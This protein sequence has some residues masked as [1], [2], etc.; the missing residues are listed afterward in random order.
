MAY[1]A[2]RVFAQRIGIALHL[3]EQRGFEPYFPQIR[4]E[5]GRVE[6]LFAHY[7]FLVA[8]DQ[9]CEARYCPGVVQLIGGRDDRPATIS[10]AVVDGLRARERGGLVEL[11]PPPAPP[12]LRRGAP[13]RITY[14]PFAG[15]GGTVWLHRGQ[16]G[17]ERLIVL[18]GM[19]R[20]EISRGAIEIV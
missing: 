2:A 7:V 12:K 14:G 4:G 18:M 10:D 6:P 16:N 3:L 20:V 1:W 5:H 11:P 13:V 8:R 15:R 17:A 19:L 9:W